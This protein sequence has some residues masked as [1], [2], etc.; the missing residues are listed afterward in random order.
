MTLEAPVLSSRRRAYS[1]AAALF[2]AFVLLT[3]CG[4]GS[5][6]DPVETTPAAQA[7]LDPSQP[8]VITLKSL[9]FGPSKITVKVGQRV[10]FVWKESVA[11][12]VVFDA[13]RKSKTVSKK[14]YTWST[15]FDAPGT[16][17]YKCN[18]HPG[19]NGQII[20]VA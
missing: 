12:N 6:G 7:V 4:G 9:R 8:Q 10:D 19:M 17:K 18:L 20:V 5:S 13:K 1:A 16:Y 14:G 2:T 11:H 15:T 3:G